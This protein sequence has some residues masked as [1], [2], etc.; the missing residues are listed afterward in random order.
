MVLRKIF[1]RQP[2]QSGRL[3]LLYNFV[4][5]FLLVSFLLRVILMVWQSPD[6]SWNLIDVVR[7]LGTGL[8]FDIGTCSF[9]LFPALLYHIIMPDRFAGS[10]ADRVITWFFISLTIFIL[11]L[12]FFAEVTFWQEFRTRFN[13][14]AVDYLIYTNE[15]VANIQQSYPLPLLIGAVLGIT[16]AAVYLLYKR[17]AFTHTFKGRL[18]LQHRFILLTTWIA[19]MAFFIAFVRNN[20]AELSANRYNNEIAKAGIYSFFAEFRNNRMKYDEFY[21]TINNDKA[22]TLVRERLNEPGCT[23]ESDGKSIL[24]HL[25][26]QDTAG[27]TNP[28]VV[29]ILMESMSAEFMAEFGNTQKLTPYMDKLAGNSI[30]FTNLDA[31]GTRTVRGMEALTLCIPPTP[32][33]SIVKRPDNHGLYTISNVFSDRGYR[34]NFF[35]GGDGYFDNMN[36]YFGGNGFTIY[37][38]GHG[39]VLSDDIEAA[40]NTIEDDEVHF[41]NAW[42][43]CDEDIYSKMLKVADTEYKK[44]Q[45]FFN[46]VMTTS[47]HRPY[48]YP[49]GRIDI[50]SGTGREGA[51]KYADYALGKML[52][53]AASKP[54]FKN[55]V[56]V[57]V[58]DHCASSAGRDEI[59]VAHYH[60]PAMIY[61]MPRNQNRRVAK[62]C[63]QIDIFPTL[64]SLLHWNYQSNFFGKD[65]LKE[66]F[67][68]RAFVGTY[69]KLAMVKNDRV[70]ILSD[71]KK[72]ACYRYDSKNNRLFAQK[73]DNAFLAETIA[74][75]QTADYLFSK[76]LLRQKAR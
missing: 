55:T 14:I 53:E 66:G 15:V 17:G 48:T 35:Y 42:G 51:V 67:D 64:F 1:D 76:G 38:R 23:F 63:S 70:T 52:K 4:S 75:Y 61:N 21:T 71:Q 41:E 2:L 56:F 33:Q 12:T 54:W 18:S 13:F 25:V 8:F 22:F 29:L 32:G 45:P 5:G 16:C 69:R 65:V 31:T 62:Q 34:N 11:V 72:Q 9:I 19:V 24:R 10:L 26:S 57:I 50:P 43:I 6:L 47:N 68:G 40:R 28:N 49:E 39:S 20:D 46:F 73:T 58:A 3:S 36:N 7:T 44:G 27:P 37:D 74:W 60:I 30:F 59:D